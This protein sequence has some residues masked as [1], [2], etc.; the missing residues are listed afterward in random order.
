MPL[1]DRAARL[2]GFVGEFL[3]LLGSWRVQPRRWSVAGRRSGVVL[4]AAYMLW[5]FQ[6]VFYGEVTN[7][8]NARPA[9]P[10]PRAR[11]CVLVPLVVAGAVHGRLAEPA[12][13]RAD[14]AVRRRAGAQRAR[15]S[16]AA[17]AGRRRRDVRAAPARASADERRVDLPVRS[18]PP[19]IVA[20]DRPDRAA[21]PG[22]HA[23]AAGAAPVAPRCRCCRPRRRPGAALI[24]L[25]GARRA[26]RSSAARYVA[27]RLHALLRTC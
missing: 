12:A 15:G 24:V 14:R 3:I 9:R 1:V 19:L 11:S 8:K 27:R 26:A 21:R 20:V 5:M 22:L 17:R 25:V 13:S 16:A 6:R 23:R 7:P 4:A 10:R 18:S 2:N